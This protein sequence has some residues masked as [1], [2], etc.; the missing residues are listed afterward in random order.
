MQ[1]ESYRIRLI[2]DF[3]RP[4]G[5]SALATRWQ[6]FSDRVMG[7]VS[8]VTSGI[9]VI[10]GRR[11]LRL[12]GEVSLEN[13]GGF[14]QVA[15]PLGPDGSSFDAGEYQG[16]RLRVWGNGERYFVHLRTEQTQRP[17]QYYAAEFTAETEWREVTIPF[18]RF[19]PQNLGV[20][21]DNSRL[22]RLAIVGAWKNFTADVAVSRIEFYR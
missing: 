20:K 22:R 15:L 18:A 7:G 17:W 3:S 11:C 9:E 4:D 1:D 12:R 13:N 2:D 21:L 6:S 5:S 10:D 14:V 19:Q 8:N 16:I